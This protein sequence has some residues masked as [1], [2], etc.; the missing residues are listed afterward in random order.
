MFN[1]KETVREV[2]LD[3]KKLIKLAKKYKKTLD[4]AKTLPPNSREMFKV[5]R[6]SGI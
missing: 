6:K 1:I 2:D 5:I 3:E 4:N